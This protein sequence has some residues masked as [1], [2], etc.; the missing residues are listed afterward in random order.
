[1]R[2]AAEAMVEAFL[3]VDGE[4]GRFLWWNGQQALNSRPALISLTDGPMTADRVVRARSS[5]SHA[6]ERVKSAIPWRG[7]RSSRVRRR[8]S[9]LSEQGWCNRF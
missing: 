5:S 8:G 6:G 9:G 2:A 3:V 7:A 1:M 4:A